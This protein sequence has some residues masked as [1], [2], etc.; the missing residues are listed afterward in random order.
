MKGTAGEDNRESVGGKE[1]GFGVWEN[2]GE[3]KSTK[4][5]ESKNAEEIEFIQ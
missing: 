5:E 2:L 4:K 1:D 3:R